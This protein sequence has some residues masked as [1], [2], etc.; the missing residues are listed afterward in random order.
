MWDEWLSH[1]SLFIRLFFDA[2]LTAEVMLHTVR[3]AMILDDESGEI[4]E[5]YFSDVDFNDTV[6]S[7]N[8]SDSLADLRP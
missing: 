1:F 5:G 2:V 3:C 7:L 6:P 8:N 4:T